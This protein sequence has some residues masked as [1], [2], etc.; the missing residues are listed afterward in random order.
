[1]SQAANPRTQR[2]VAG[3]VGALIVVVAI[4]VVWVKIGGSGQKATPVPSVD[5]AAWVKAGRTD[6]QLMLFAPSRLPSGWRATSVDYTAGAAAHWHLGLLTDTGK[7]V[8]I[9]ESRASAEELAQQYVDEEA[10][11]G[12]DVTVGGETW[13]TWTDVGGDYALVRPVALD[14]RP[15]ETVLVGGSGAPEA[16]RK[17]VATLTTG[18]IRP[19]VG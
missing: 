14:G 11:R 9:E 19:S 3:M 18:T 12:V 6:Q 7:Y 2:S 15:Y 17:F 10:V 8:G 4:G 16:T 13:Q 1:M 5:W